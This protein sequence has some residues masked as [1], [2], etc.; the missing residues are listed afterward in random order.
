MSEPVQQ[1]RLPRHAYLTEENIERYTRSTLKGHYGLLPSE[2]WWKDR[3]QYL[4]EAG[5]VLRPRY[6]PNW[7]PSWLGTN[8][9]PMYCEDSIMQADYQILDAK[10]SR[11]N[12][13]VAIKTIRKDTQEMPVMQFL[14]SIRHPHNHTV[15][16]IQVLDD[17]YDPELL[18]MVM[19]YLRPCNNPDFATVGDAIQFINQ[20]LEGLAFMHGNRVAHRDIAM[21]NIMMDAKALYPGGHHPVRLNY[22]SDAIKPVTPLPRTGHDIKYYYIDFGLSCRFPDGASHY[23]VGDVG[24]DAEVPELSSTVPYDAFKVDIYALGNLY[25]KEFEQKYS[26]MDFLAPLI[27]RMK[28]RQPQLRPPADDLLA[29]WKNIR[30]SLGSNAH[31]WRLSPKSEPAIG[32]MLNDTVAVAW[33]GINRLKDCV[34]TS[35]VSY[36]VCNLGGSAVARVGM[37]IN[38]SLVPVDKGTHTVDY[39]GLLVQPTSSAYNTGWRPRCCMLRSVSEYEKDVFNMST[40]AVGGTGRTQLLVA[41]PSPFYLHVSVAF[42]ET[43]HSWDY[44]ICAL[45]CSSVDGTKHPIGQLQTIA[46]ISCT[47]GYVLQH[48]PHITATYTRMHAYEAASASYPGI[49]RSYISGM[50][51]SQRSPVVVSLFSLP[52]SRREDFVAFYADPNP[53]SPECAVRFCSP[54][55]YLYHLAVYGLSRRRRSEN[56]KRSPE[57]ACSS[58]GHANQ[59]AQPRTRLKPTLNAA[60]ASRMTRS[61]KA[62]QTLLRYRNDAL[63]RA[64]TRYSQGHFQLRA[65]EAAA[66]GIDIRMFALKALSGFDDAPV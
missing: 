29:Q 41:H 6:W 53:A 14:S 25:A 1:K 2:I 46:D 10:R 38:R 19:P 31:R 50:V 51:H 22:S 49:I 39:D 57:H 63:G 7:R 9:H 18:L 5:Y 3:Q 45:R 54:R 36:A 65:S 62:M 40:D 43:R 16:L 35:P 8:L 58:A 55:Q 42:T 52:T 12:D 20:T 61:T 13:I 32:R 60:D 48:S 30:D 24:R 11:E 59:N 34:C 21:K 4:F 47:Y 37:Q 66:N 44:S 26:N 56:Q 23:V 28:Q 27:E 17:P 15:P 33:E 64:I